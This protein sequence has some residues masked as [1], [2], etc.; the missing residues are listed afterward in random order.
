MYIAHIPTLPKIDIIIGGW[1]VKYILNLII[2][3]S[4]PSTDKLTN[5]PSQLN[6]P[7]TMRYALCPMPHH[8]AFPHPNSDLCLLPSVL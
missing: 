3:K 1:Q 6:Q 8:S 4:S 5:Q 7:P 2:V